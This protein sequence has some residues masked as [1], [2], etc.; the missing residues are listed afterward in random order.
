MSLRRIRKDAKKLINYSN[1]TWNLK[2][3]FRGFE[4]GVAF[5]I[6]EYVLEESVIPDADHTVQRKIYEKGI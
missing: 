6:G 1:F 3:I 4:E 2:A 5:A